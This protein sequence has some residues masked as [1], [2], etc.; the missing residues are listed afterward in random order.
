MTDRIFSAIYDRKVTRE[1][2]SSCLAFILLKV[3][4]LLAL[5]AVFHTTAYEG[6][7]NE[8]KSLNGNLLMCNG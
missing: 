1:T 7:D 5:R 3:S 6:K 2:E 8:G 4:I